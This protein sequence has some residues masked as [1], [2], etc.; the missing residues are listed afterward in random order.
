MSGQYEGEK[1]GTQAKGLFKL[2]ASYSY[3]SERRRCMD[4]EEFFRLKDYDS[5]ALFI[6]GSFMQVKKVKYY[7]DHQL[8]A[9]M[10][11]HEIAIEAER[12]RK[13]EVKINESI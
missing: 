10:R 7:K 9:L 2:P 8:S 4:P 5:V 3:N 13:N 11:H 6:D 12:N 1:T